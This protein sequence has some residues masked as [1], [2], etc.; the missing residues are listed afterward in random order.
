MKKILEGTVVLDL[1]RFFSGPQATL[2]L[3][4][5]GAEVIKIDD[6]ATGDPT[7]FSPPFVGPKGVS[8][9]RQSEQDMGIAYLKRARAK[10][11]VCL[12]LKTAEGLR[13]FRK[14]VKQADVV[15]ENFSVGVAERLGVDFASLSRINPAL[16]HCSLTGYGTTGPDSRLKAYDLMVQAAV[17]LMGITGHP[18]APPVKAGS[19]LSDAIAGVFAA[20]GIVSAL[21]HR[22]RT[23]EGQ[24]VDVS[25]A[26][27]LFAL[28]FDEPF[29]CYDALALPQ[30]QGS[31]IMRF[32]PFNSYEAL[33]G[34]V[35]VGAAT[36]ADWQAL[37][38]VMGRE[39]LRADANMMDL[40]WRLANN[41]KVDTIVAD[42]TRTLSS[43][44]I[45]RLLN[46]VQVPC[47]PIRTMAQALSWPHLLARGMVR[48]LWNPLTDAPACASG[49]GFPVKFSATP[50]DYDTPAPLPGQ[51]TAEILARLGGCSAEDIRAL[52]AAGITNGA[53]CADANL[54]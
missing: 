49:P 6:P 47:S 8:F 33:D 40:G 52:A 26:D 9:Q 5:M 31:R 48:P 36:S 45:I 2:L 27:C 23:G 12:D 20:T 13:V 53:G 28:L 43:D 11:S 38:R 21:L 16:V 24:S 30:R 32:S 4:G 14:M 29:D 50:G 41:A 37:L 46:A 3:A 39:D 22:D 35:V 19:P 34:W 51:H 10:K 42:W 17:G 1:T 54:D 7:T 44:E 18:Q 25:M 15:I